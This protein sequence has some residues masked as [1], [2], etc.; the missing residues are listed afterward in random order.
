M[1]SFPLFHAASFQGDI[2]L[3]HLIPEVQAKFAPL[4]ADLRPDLVA[5]LARRGVERLYSHQAEAYE[6]VRKGRHVVVVTPTA[7]GKTL[8]YSLPDL[9]RRLES[10][11]TRALSLYPTKPLAQVQ[12]AELSALKHGLPI[13]LRVD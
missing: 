1:A 7:R 5:A 12:L 8:C 3:D 2:T 13:E 9:H 11:E 4:P 6:A 10:P